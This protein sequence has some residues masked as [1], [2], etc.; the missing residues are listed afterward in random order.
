LKDV[1]IARVAAGQEHSLFLHP[2]GNVIYACGHNGYKQCGVQN[3][4]VMTKHSEAAAKGLDDSKKDF[5]LLKPARVALPIVERLDEVGRVVDI[6]AGENHSLAVTSGGKLYTWGYGL[7]GAVGIDPKHSSE[8]IQP[9]LSHDWL[10]NTDVFVHQ[11][12]AGSQHSVVV[13][14][15]YS[16]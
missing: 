14:T 13:A 8:D 3:E 10:P 6:A 5:M 15:R 12:S 9:R 16:K 1:P 2:R 7:Y 11:A 4:K